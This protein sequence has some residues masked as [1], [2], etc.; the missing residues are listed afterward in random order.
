MEA[1][2]GFTR[3]KK[4]ESIVLPMGWPPL[5]KDVVS[6]FGFKLV[7]FKGKDTWRASTES[8]FRNSLLSMGIAKTKVERHIRH[9]LSMPDQSICALYNGKC[10]G[11]CTVGE[12]VGNI[13]Q[14][15]GN[16]VACFCE[17]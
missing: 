11:Q 4:G 10:P 1:K 7:K 13:D 15:T 8:D 14:V 2:K 16:V 12:C 17:T 9:K 3:F 5:P 6:L